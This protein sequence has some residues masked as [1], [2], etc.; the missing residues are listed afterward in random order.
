MK[1]LIIALSITMV[2]LFIFA[3]LYR[4]LHE[5]YSVPAYNGANN[6]PPTQPLYD[7]AK[8][9][10]AV[11]ANNDGTELFD[12]LAPFYL[13]NATGKAN[14]YIVAKKHSPIR[15]KKGVFILPQF[16]FSG[17]DSAGIKP[18]VIV[19]PFLSA[20]DSSEQDPVI[21]EWVKKH[22]NASTV[23]LSVCDGSATAAATGIFDGKLLTAHS[24]DFESIKRNFKKPVW[25][26]DKAV[27][28][29]GNLYSTAGVSNASEGSLLVIGDFFG[30]ETMERV[31][32]E[33][34]YPY[35]SPRMSHESITLSLSDKGRMI[36]KDLFQSNKNVAVVIGDGMSEF[37]LAAVMDVYNR[38][39]PYSI[40]SVSV[41][42]R[43]I[44]TKFGLTVI[45]TGK[46]SDQQFDEIHVIDSRGWH[47]DPNKSTRVLS[48]SDQDNHYIID[49][50]LERI[51][52]LYGSRFEQ[53]V[54][55]S[56]D[57]N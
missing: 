57:F 32:N 6:F 29:T 34:H 33:I 36:S 20:T 26:K 31:I 37:D 4:P 23:L 15:M 42:G 1:R 45:P 14:V 7:S 52:N 53:A 3:R 2:L 54:K 22:F 30:K 19:I 35:P 47:P 50:C 51:R 21:I 39:L 28:K 13:F 48:Y 9:T 27:V 38:T 12:M 41:D 17:M 10:V 16:T 18:D 8:K 46:L 40:K 24:S 49:I 43:P 56:L 5:V 44:K 11:I 25:V 55:R